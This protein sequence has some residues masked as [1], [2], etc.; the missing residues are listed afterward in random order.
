MEKKGKGA[1]WAA[2]GSLAQDAGLGRRRRRPAARTLPR[3]SGAPVRPYPPQ[4][5]QPT[6]HPPPIRVI[7]AR[8]G[9]PVAAL[10]DDR[11][12]VR[13]RPGDGPR[14]TVRVMAADGSLMAAFQW[15]GGPLAAAGWSDEEDLVFV[16]KSGEVWGGGGGVVV[17]GRE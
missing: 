7:P 13:V 5:T 6:S 14:P 11:R 3:P 17:A 4:H 12:V 8:D 15:D 16:A 1:S 9:G 2:V 10:R